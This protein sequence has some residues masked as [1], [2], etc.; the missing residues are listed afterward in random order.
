MAWNQPNLNPKPDQNKPLPVRGLVAGLV[1][2]IIATLCFFVFKGKG[3]P[4]NVRERA[5]RTIKEVKPA[6]SARQ[7]VAKEIME[8]PSATVANPPKQKYLGHI[9]TQSF[10]RV[11][12]LADGTVT[13]LKSRVAF[14]NRMEQVLS[15]ALNP[16]GI[17]V[18]LRL[19]LRRY[20][21]QQLHDMFHTD[22]KPEKGDDEF[23]LSRKL[24][25]QEL[26]IQVR[27]LEKEGNSYT[28]IFDEI[29]N[30]GRNARAEVKAAR[31]GLSQL[32]KAGESPEVLKAWVDEKNVKLKELGEPPLR[33][34]AQFLEPQEP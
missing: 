5:S 25:L 32:I 13:N 16:R 4:P 31:Q 1:C 3:T 18:P 19:A 12:T 24:E 23:I 7:D 17:A 28:E 9:T 11:V 20:S 22:L 14:T 34:P 33:V 2:V 29:D 30:I 15:S 6:I 21:E 27:E 26:K 10:S 8:N